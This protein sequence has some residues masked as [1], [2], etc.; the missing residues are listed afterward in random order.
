M[1][2]SGDTAG[3]IIP[4]DCDAPEAIAFRTG[5]AQLAPTGAFMVGGPYG[6]EAS[7]LAVPLT[8]NGEVIGVMTFIDGPGRHFEPDDVSL[9]SEVASRTG[10]ALSNATRFQREHVVAEVLQRA[11]LPDFL[12]QVEGLQLDAEYRAGVAGT[13]VGGDWYD[14]FE[15]DDDQVVFSVGD[16]MGKGA[17]AA[18][19]MGQARTAIRAYAVAGQSPS[20]VLASLDHLFDT[21]VEDRIVTAVVGTI[22]PHTGAVTLANAGH[23]P[24]MILRGDGSHEYTGTTGSLLIAA[25]L[26]GFPRPLHKFRLAPGDSLIMY[27]DGLVE[28]RGELLSTGMDRLA[29]RGNTDCPRRLAGQSGRVLGLAAE[30]R[31]AGRRRGGAH[32][33]H[34]GVG[35][36][37]KR[38]G[39][40]YSTRWHVD[41]AAR[42]GGA[43]HARWPGTGSPPT[44]TASRPRRPS[45]PPCSPPSW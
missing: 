10:V 33:A 4:F 3:E 7:A 15:L 26:G 41:P 12:P 9:A 37:Y 32:R 22:N 21:L 45:A 39:P 36:R 31:R 11:V 28:R 29:R 27:S 42:P 23:P 2:G 20:E 30:R 40:G 17:P 44:C 5:R 18:A 24:P 13:Y 34:G 43:E 25:G 16:V 14:V 8:A 19:L 38:S 35:R 1:A 6:D